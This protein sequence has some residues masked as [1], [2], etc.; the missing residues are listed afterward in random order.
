M[1]EIREAPVRS[2]SHH[3][4]T[5]S[6]RGSQFAQQALPQNHPVPRYNL[7]V[8]MNKLFYFLT[9]AAFAIPAFAMDYVTEEEM[10]DPVEPETVAP[11]SVDP[12]TVAPVEVAPVEVDPLE[13]PS[14][15][16]GSECCCVANHDGWDM[17]NESPSS[18]DNDCSEEIA[19][20]YEIHH[21]HLRSGGTEDMYDFEGVM[22]HRELGFCWPRS[23]R[24]PGRMKFEN[25]DETKLA[26]I[27]EDTEVPDHTTNPRN[28]VW[29]PGDGFCVKGLPYMWFKVPNHCDAII[30]CVDDGFEMQACCNTCAAIWLDYNDRVAF[31]MWRQAPLPRGDWPWC[32]QVEGW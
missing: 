17:W 15:F 10:A 24:K 16:P 12:E 11:V 30:T 7:F 20:E 28:G 9:L 21:R 18:C 27:P 2:H 1:S 26:V 5:Q 19:V 23:P 14:S 31:P 22:H 4:G 32:D 8:I 3:Q 6:R 25:C 29:H 13:S